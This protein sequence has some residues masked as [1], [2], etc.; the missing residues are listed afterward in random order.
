MSLLTGERRPPMPRTGAPYR[1]I[2]SKWAAALLYLVLIGLSLLLLTPLF[3]MLSTS[4]K[5][6][7]EIMSYPPTLLPKVIHFENYKHAW[8]KGNFARYTLNTLLLAGIGVLSH[9][10]SNTFVAYGFAKIRFPGKRL[11]F[12]VML[13]TMMIPSFVTLIPQYILFS[14]LSWINTYYPLTVPGFFGSAFQIFLIRQF[15]MTIPNELIEAGKVDGA[16]HFRIWWQL[17]LPLSLPVIATVA[18][19]TFQGAWNDF[20][21][22]LI[23]INSESLFNLQ[24]G[25]QSFKGTESTQWHYLMAGSVIVLLPVVLLFFFF[26]RYFIEG[27]NITAGTKG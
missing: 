1:T 16:S 18:I 6:M 4:L 27:M 5:S 20:T 10:L 21:G 22:P 8:E 2:R 24:I 14:K 25:L 12:A 23:Y 3:W 15:F 19:M 13:G 11:L 17:M 9:V 7:Q 26:Q